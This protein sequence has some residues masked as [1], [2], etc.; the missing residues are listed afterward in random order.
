MSSSKRKNRTSHDNDAKRGSSRHVSNDVADI[1]P[2]V[3]R[4]AR[5]SPRNINY[6]LDIDDIPIEKCCSGCVCF[7]EFATKPRDQCTSDNHKCFQAWKLEPNEVP[8]IKRHH[9]NTLKACMEET[10]R[11]EWSALQRLNLPAADAQ[12]QQSEAED[13]AEAEAEGNNEGKEDDNNQPTVTPTPKKKKVN[14][15]KQKCAVGGVVHWIDLPSTHRIIHSNH[16]SRWETNSKT[17]KNVRDKSQSSQCDTSYTFTQA[18]W[19]IGMASVPHLAMSAA[20]FLFPIII[21]AFLRDTGLFDYNDFALPHLATSFP[22][23]WSF[24]KFNLHQAARDVMSLGFQLTNQKIFM[25]CDKGNKKGVSH[26]VKVLSWWE[27]SG[28][29]GVRLLN[30]DGSGGTSSDC[31]DAI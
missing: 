28:K 11:I 15:V 18:L 30:I 7:N 29:V 4:R 9:H 22:S 26:F 20:Q 16:C 1:A 13:E 31:A 6:C 19:A 12:Q 14:W 2:T 17:L 21:Y 25:A 24:R 8:Q 5:W 27:R 3:P 23:D 10:L